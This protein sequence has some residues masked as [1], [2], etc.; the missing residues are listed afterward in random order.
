[1][2]LFGAYLGFLYF[3][4]ELESEDMGNIIFRNGKFRPQNIIEYMKYPF[5]SDLFWIYPVVWKHN[6]LIT[7]GVGGIL[8]TMLTYIS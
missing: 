7:T 4:I 3:V 5:M 1:M 2:F 8:F 6:W